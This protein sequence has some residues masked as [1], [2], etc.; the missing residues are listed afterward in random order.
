M[1]FSSSL[2]VVEFYFL[3]RFPIPFGNP[4]M[5]NSVYKFC[6]HYQSNCFS[7]T[8]PV[9]SCSCL[10]NLRFHIGWILGSVL[11][12]EARTCA[13]ESIPDCLHPLLS[14]LRQCSYHG[15]RQKLIDHYF[16]LI[17][18]SLLINVIKIQPTNTLGNVSQVLPK[19]I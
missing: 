10:P 7:K 18:R 19:N 8:C 16:N 2:S 15:Y 4:W 1:M 14:H 9:S 3:H 17:N 12:P 6:K 13:Q 5:P 11:G